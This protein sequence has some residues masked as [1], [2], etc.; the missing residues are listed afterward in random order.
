MVELSESNSK[1]IYIPEG[2]AHGFYTLD[3][4]NYV[5]YSCTNYR[6]EKR[7]VGLIWN[8]KNLKIKWPAKMPIISQ[9]DKK[10]ISFKEYKKK[11][12]I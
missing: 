4:E 2:F 5:L 10:N 9:K 3:K 11:F 1:S 6:N 8:D 12:K 7:E